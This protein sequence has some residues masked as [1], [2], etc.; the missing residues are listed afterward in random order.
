LIAVAATGVD[1]IDL[2][3]ARSAGITVSNIRNYAVQGVP[4]HALMLMLALTKNL[5]AYRTDVSNGLWQESST[6]CLF[7]HRI[8]DLHRSKLGIIGYGA[9]GRATADLARAFGMEVLVSEH[10]GAPRVR[11]GRTAFERVLETSDIVSLHAPLHDRTRHLI[12]AAELSRMKPSVIL[13]NTARGALVDET[14]LAQALSRGAIGGVGLDV[15]REEPPRS[16]S[17]LLALSHLPNVIVTPHVGWASARTMEALADQLVDN[18][19]AFA[20]GEPKNAVA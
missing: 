12:G 18:I 5:I 10:R 20:A 4:E 15:L 16:G 3:F 19:E 6:F 11:E 17:P 14:A 2:A 8:T 9:L 1:I 7:T 13:I